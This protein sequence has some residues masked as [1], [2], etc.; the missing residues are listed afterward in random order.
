MI[1]Y[2]H[3]GVHVELWDCFCV[4][5]YCC[6]CSCDLC[7]VDIAFVGFVFEFRYA[8]SEADVYNSD[9]VCGFIDEDVGRFDASMDDSAFVEETHCA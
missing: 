1:E 3:E 4:G 7:R 8:E 6:G 9:F 5:V 2:D